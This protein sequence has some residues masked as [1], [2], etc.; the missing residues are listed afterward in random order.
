MVI[1]EVGRRREVFGLLDYRREIMELL[2]VS[3]A[4]RQAGVLFYSW[5]LPKRTG[6]WIMI[7]L[8]WDM[9]NETKDGPLVTRMERCDMNTFAVFQCICFTLVYT[10]EISREHAALLYKCYP[11]LP[12]ATCK[13]SYK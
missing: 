2:D 5:Y 8:A 12:C 3:T 4:I 9:N 1:P 10:V 7:L 13:Y 11:F 6:S